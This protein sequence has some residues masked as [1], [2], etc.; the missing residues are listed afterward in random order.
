MIKRMLGR[1]GEEVSI[2]GFGGI[3]VRSMQ[4]PEANEVVAEAV[5][6]GVNYFDVAPSYGDAEDRLGPALE[7][8]GLSS[9]V[10]TDTY[11]EV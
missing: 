2:F 10:S 3:V 9:A 11:A 1:T 6:R 8:F 5:E 4:Q 7:I